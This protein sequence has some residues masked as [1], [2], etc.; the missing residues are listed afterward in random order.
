MRLYTYR[1]GFAILAGDL[2]QRPLVTLRKSIEFETLIAHLIAR[3]RD[4]LRDTYLVG[5]EQQIQLARFGVHRQAADEEC[6]HLCIRK[7]ERTERKR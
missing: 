5:S 6:A 2:Q 7:K 1:C 4:Q 3:E